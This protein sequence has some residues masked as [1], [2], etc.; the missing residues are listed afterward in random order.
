MTV[1]G[2]ATGWLT[3]D[4]HQRFR[5]LMLHTAA[6]EG[7]ICPAYSMMPDH[8]HLFWMGLRR[9]TDQLNGMAFLRTHFEPSLAPARFQHQAHD[10]VLKESERKQNAFAQTCL[11]VLNNA[12]KSGLAT[13]VEDW[14]DCGAIVPGYPKMHPTDADYWEKLWRIVDKLRSTD[15]NNHTLPPIH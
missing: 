13:K 10:H 12:V 6:R 15:C 11:Y 8:I 7:L 5:E 9:D 2:R 4:C 3:P 14:P 1:E